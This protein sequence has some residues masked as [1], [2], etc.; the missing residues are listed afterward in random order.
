MDGTRSDFLAPVRLLLLSLGLA[1]VWIVISLVVAANSAHA[2]EADSRSLLGG[3]VSG[4][5]SAAVTPLTDATNALDSQVA[6]A[7]PAVR[8]TVATVATVAPVAQ[9]VASKPVSSTVAPVAAAVDTVVA[10]VVAPVAKV[11]PVVAPVATPVLATVDHVVDA[12]PVSDRLPQVSDLLGEAPIADVT[13][14][15]TALVDD[16]LVGVTAP[17]TDGVLPTLPS[18]PSVPGLPSLDALAGS[19]PPASLD[20]SPTSSVSFEAFVAKGDRA[21]YALAASGLAASTFSA[22]TIRSWAASLNSGLGVS[23]A[24]SARPHP[25]SVPRGPAENG[26]SAL[27]SA[28]PASGAAAGGPAGPPSAAELAP[29]FSMALISGALLSRAE[30]D[31]LPSP[32]ALELSSTPD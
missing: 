26:S 3:A 2:D 4:V 31:V 14:P 16:V 9:A 28:P 11:A 21:T 8:S 27:P 17:A 5:A 25:D 22:A 24:A 30:N 32:L 23:P 20:A 13:A 1:A 12:L 18:L 29:S 10:P 6:A 15:V 19:V 7:A